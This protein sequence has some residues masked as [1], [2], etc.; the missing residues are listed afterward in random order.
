M[1]LTYRPEIDG[2]RAIAVLSVIFYHADFN[3]LGY[4]MFKGGFFGVDI[5]F[6]ISGYLITSLILKE[7]VKTKK[8]SYTNFFERRARR[9]LPPLFLVIFISTVFAWFM[10]LPESLVNFSESVL[11]SIFFNSN[12]YFWFTGQKYGEETGLLVPLLHTWSLSIEEQFYI[13]F[14]IILLII[15]RLNKKRLN[16]IISLMFII[17]FGLAIFAANRYPMFNFFILPTR[18]W[19]LL[20]GSLIAGIKVFQIDKKK[21]NGKNLNKFLPTIG[22]LLIIYSILFID[23]P[24]FHPSYYTLV[25]ILGSSLIIFFANN[26]EIICKS[27]SNKFFVSIGL[28]SYSLYLWHYPVFSFFERNSFFLKNDFSKIILILITFILSFF[29]YVLV[30]KKFRGFKINSKKFFII[31]LSFFAFLSIINFLIIKKDGF[32]ERLNLSDL[33]KNFIFN[34]KNYENYYLDDPINQKFNEQK[35]KL[36]VVGNSHGKDFYDILNSNNG[37]K[38]IFEIKYLNFSL[39]C[40]QQYL[41]A[42]TNRCIRTFDFN[43]R[44]IFARQIDNFL[45]AE[46]VILSTR[47]SEA[48][49]NSLSFLNEFFKKNKMDFTVV[50]TAPEFNFKN[51]IYSNLNLKHINKQLFNSTTIMDRHVLLKNEIPNDI[52]KKYFE[53]LYFK[54]I[55]NT[56]IEINNKLKK[57]SKVMNINFLD[58]FEIFCNLKYNTC[59]VLT[60]SNE[61]IH[62]DSSG[63]ISLSGSKFFGEKIYNS[64]VYSKF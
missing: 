6:V 20:A 61:K 51:K 43:K 13:F 11:S 1:K 12:H 22:I 40:L 24:T 38:K 42:N 29:S 39:E 53:K 28:I 48:D 26:E 34:K 15:F 8:F 9:I 35:K 36:I 10:F 50:S 14:P 25:P 64:N 55:K 58:L 45:T 21:H 30:E 5:F 59:D 62:T 41:E 56:Q 18:G 19:E 54:R 4:S 57:Q 46:K 17:S 63:H 23:N 7:L 52:E 2:L 27:L 37:I 47:W 44:D 3:F 33:Q 32:E 60:E 16:L 31:I 49:I